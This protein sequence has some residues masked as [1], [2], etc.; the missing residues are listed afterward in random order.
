VS[1]VRVERQHLD[2]LFSLIEQMVEE[3][4]FRHAKPSRAKIE[5][6]F[7]YP[8]SVAFLAYKG[9]VCIGFVA[10]IVDSFFFS[11]YV[12]A[13]DLGFYILPEHRGGRAAFYLLRAVE[14]WAKDQGVTELYMG[15]SV[16]G[17]IE[18]MKKFYIHNGYSIGGFNSVKKL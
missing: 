3:S 12:R 18:E 5:K 8:K 17:K 2:L 16:G 14:T 9:D 15:Q 4:V 6:L 1:I 7:N 11:D 10:A 13:T